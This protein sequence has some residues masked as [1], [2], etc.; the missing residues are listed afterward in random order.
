MKGSA[1]EELI[2]NLPKTETHLHIEGA[3]PWEMLRETNP[4]KFSSIPA[5]RKPDFR[6]ESFEQFES[7]LIDHALLVFNSAESYYN[8]AQR[9]FENHLAEK[10]RY[11][12]TSFHAG[13]MEFLKI[14]GEEILSAILAAV[15]KGLTVRVFMGISRNAY[16]PYL[17]PAWRKRLKN[18]SSL[19]ESIFMAW[20][21]FRWR[22]GRFLSGKRLVQTVLQSRLTLENSDLPKTFRMQSNDWEFGGYS[23][24]CVRW[25]AKKS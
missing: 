6:Y 14:P 24:A 11:V 16:T 15:P 1:V 22:I 10:V 20:R 12:E 9:I 23:M 18:G 25:K 13:M 4:E 3:L 7:I 5:F 8:A 2:A 19:L 21:V 17:A